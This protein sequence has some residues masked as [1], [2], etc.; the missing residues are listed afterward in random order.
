MLFMIIERFNDRDPAPRGR[1]DPFCGQ[2]RARARAR[3]GS[4]RPNLGRHRGGFGFA[5]SE[6]D[7]RPTFRE[8]CIANRQ[9]R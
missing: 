4:G 7:K 5:A 3:P 6:D 1:E 2:V 8:S 9:F